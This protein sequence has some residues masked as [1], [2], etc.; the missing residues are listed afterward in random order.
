MKIKNKWRNKAPILYEHII[1][2]GWSIKA[3]MDS[4]ISTSKKCS[5]EAIPRLFVF[6][7]NRRNQ[8]TVL[9]FSVR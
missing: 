9:D 4:C 2:V 6:I 7:N 5:K 1:P 3:L 8:N